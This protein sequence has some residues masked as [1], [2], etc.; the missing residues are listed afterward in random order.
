MP[1][2]ITAYIGLGCNLGDCINS[3]RDAARALGHIEGIR[4]RRV[5]P[6]YRTAPVGM[7]GQPEFL[8]TVAEVATTLPP[9]DLLNS[10]LQV[11]KEL[12][13]V[14]Q[15]RWGPRVIDLDLLLYGE[16]HIVEPGLEVPHPRLTERAFV[17]VPL[18][19][20]APELILP[21][22]V[23]AAV[24]AEELRKKQRVEKVLGTEWV[25]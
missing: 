22:G 16:A 18:A 9:R 17:A 24:L 3:L 5:A 7:S 19:E 10:L 25:D 2:G 13:R 4:I 11:E 12:G 21:G 1:E 23:T 8:N 14:R 15:E 20:L 6:L